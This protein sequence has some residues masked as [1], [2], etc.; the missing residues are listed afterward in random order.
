MR[1]IVAFML[2]FSA[3]PAVQEKPVFLSHYAALDVEPSADPGSP[4]WKGIQG[5]VIEKSVLGPVVPQYR[6]EVRSRWTSSHIYFLFAGPYEKLTLKPD[7][8]LVKETYRLWERDCFEVYLGASY[9]N[10][11]GT[12]TLYV[13][14]QLGDRTWLAFAKGSPAELAREIVHLNR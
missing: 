2:L 12:V 1:S 5:V 6:A 10:D 9:I 3:L 8:D 11:A 14:A 7:P 4:F 13:Y